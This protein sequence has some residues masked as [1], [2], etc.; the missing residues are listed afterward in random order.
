MDHYFL[1]YSRL[2]AVDVTRE[3]ADQLVAGPPSYPTWLDERD[4]QAAR[5]WDDQIRDA[6]QGCAALLFVMTP[7]SVRDHSNCKAEWVWAL[8]HKKPVIPLRMDLD[9]EL[10][11]RLGSLQRIDFTDQF[12]IGLA[13]LRRHLRWRTTPDGVLEE[14][15]F[16]LGDA[17]RELGRT[18]GRDRGRILAD[19]TELQ[20]RVAAAEA[21]AAD[22][23]G[24]AAAVSE[25]IAVGLAV[26]RQP[27][28]DRPKVESVA[29][30]ARFVNAPPLLV[31]SYF[32]DRQPE[33]RQV[34]DA[35]RVPGVRLVSVVGRGGVG[36]TAVV[37]RL[38]K[39]LES[40]VLPDSLGEW[41][42]GGVVYLR[43]PGEHPVNFENLF[44]DLCRLLP[45]ERAQALMAR[46]RAGAEPAGVLM[47][48][49][50]DA[51]PVEGPPVLVLLDNFEDLLDADSGTVTDG[52]LDAALRALLSAPAHAVTVLL[53][54]REVPR[55][56]L[57]HAPSAVRPVNLDKGLPKSFA[58][59]V[60]RERDPDGVLGLRDAPDEMLAE[61]ARRVR[62]FPRALEALAAILAVDRTA[63]V[64][65]LL[66]RTKRLP[67]NV[68]QAV[69]GEAFERLD[70]LAQQV[71]VAL[72]VFPVPVP[73][74]AVDFLLEP[75]VAGVD[76]G[77]VL[78]R[79][80]GMQF[81]RTDARRFHLHQVD[82]DYALSRISTTGAAAAVSGP[83][84][85]LTALRR[86]AAKYFAQVETP[87]EQWRTL[88]D[89]GPVLAQVQLRREIGDYDSAAGLL[90]RISSRYLL[91]W[92][93]ARYALELFD[94]LLE[95]LTQ[96]SLRVAVLLNLG[97]C[98][99]N[100]TETG[101]AIEL[102]EQA[103][104]I[105][106][107]V[108]DR[109]AQSAA[110]S[111]LGIGHGQLGQFGRAIELHERSLA[112]DREIGNRA[113]EAVSLS[114]LGLRYSALGELERA[115][116]LQEQAL[117]IYR[118]IGDELG[119]ATALGNLGLYYSRTGQIGQAIELHEQALIIDR[120]ISYREGE[121]ADLG[122][123]GLCHADL[124]QV[125][126]AIELQEQA[127]VI[128]CEIGD[129]YL[130]GVGLVYLSGCYADLDRH[131]EAMR[132][133]QRAVQI[134]AGTGN[135]EVIAESRTW[136]AQLQLWTGDIEA[137]VNSLT[138]TAEVN[139][140][141]L[142]GQAAVLTG[143][144]SLHRDDPGRARAAF[145]EAIEHAA[146]R[147]IHASEDY[148]SH[149]IQGL[150]HTGLA[151]LDCCSA[152]QAEPADASQ[153]D[154]GNEHI[155]AAIAAF[156]KARAITTA[157]GIVGRLNRTLDTF[158]SFDT[159][160]VLP[161]IRGEL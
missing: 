91:Q 77:P 44:S 151:I 99:Q 118:E 65:E 56:L 145:E 110:L 10:P 127:L 42:V 117:V 161:R 101:Q 89:L 106:R 55:G 22:P 122:N 38:L 74:V 128:A 125:D 98:C 140:P 105:G 95:R 119:V 41:P 146:G 133:L 54:S 124:G 142:A 52:D 153:N 16:R 27:I 94:G 143:L 84:W 66:E 78:S 116:E 82:R 64:A 100:L 113:G 5:D 137:A 97:G 14:L 136:L 32:Q 26:E 121:A 68:V 90:N 12:A 1:S 114:G 141:R 108:G 31:P 30:P 160:R 75:F 50:L 139:Y 134:G 48:A 13:Q 130:E 61:A 3:L 76:A 40:G 71:M 23:A 60:L 33:T 53:T 83:V 17:E 57:L 147:L 39:G 138:R 129:R 152:N 107:E 159:N 67:D 63:T 120:A 102:F 131:D 115:I 15:R 2:D 109:R 11:F 112:I 18:T 144:A 104:T 157:P 29:G 87:R 28:A 81:V 103:L 93:H 69:V 150:A 19:V 25:R 9:A 158:K 51:F 7:D 43:T 88:D 155:Q 59:Q 35:I 49:V 123:L 156:G 46:L 4:A 58:V 72:A 149:N 80:V 85:S 79:L 126:R 96:P 24:V 45:T 8:K 154:A 135:A 6:I 21:V 20:G 111:N 148:A 36:K 92:G 62:G 70:G 132:Q 47:A 86:R 37:C 73:A 34:A